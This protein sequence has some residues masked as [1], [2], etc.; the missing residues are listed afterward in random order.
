MLLSSQCFLVERVNSDIAA[1][2]LTTFLKCSARGQAAL[3]CNTLTR[4]TAEKCNQ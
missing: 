3:Y 1:R 4:N 2:L